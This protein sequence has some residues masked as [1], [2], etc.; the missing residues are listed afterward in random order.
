M[1]PIAILSSFLMTAETLRE[2]DINCISPPVKNVYQ[3]REVLRHNTVH[4]GQ[5]S[6]NSHAGFNVLI[7][8]SN[9][10]SEM[11][12][13]GCITNVVWYVTSKSQGFITNILQV[14]Y[15]RIQYHHPAMA[16]LFSKE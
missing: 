10:Q 1:T 5:F 8:L 4:F 13:R 11:Y 2:F 3:V 9:L 7:S 12:V 6:T 14:Y 15:Y 16:R